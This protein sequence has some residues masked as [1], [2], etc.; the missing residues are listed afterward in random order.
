MLFRSHSDIK[1]M[2]DTVENSHLLDRF[3]PY[4]QGIIKTI[5][6]QT[7]VSDKQLNY[8]KAAYDFIQDDKKD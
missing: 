6:G 8:L 3:E 7:W 2:V 4:I 1:N 5:A